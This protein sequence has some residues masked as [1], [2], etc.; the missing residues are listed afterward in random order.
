MRLLDHQREAMARS[1]GRD[2]FAFFME[3]G[4]GKSLTVIEDASRSRLSRVL[5][6]APSGVHGTWSSHHLSHLPV[7]RLVWQNRPALIK[8][9]PEICKTEEFFWLLMSYDSL[10]TDAGERAATKFLKTSE[11]V[12]LILDES[13]RIKSPSAN[14]TRA[15]LRISKLTSWRRVLSGTPI[16][17]KPLDIYSQMLALSPTYWRE[18]FGVPNYH[19]FKHEFAVWKKVELP[20]GARFEKLIGYRHLDRLSAT[21]AKDSFRVLKRDVIKDLPEKTYETVYVPA[22]DEQ[23]RLLAQLRDEL[24]ME[25]SS[26]VE[27][28]APLAIAR[29]TRAQQ[30]LGGTFPGTSER[31]PCPRLE[32]TLELLED[33]SQPTIVWCRFIEDVK[34]IAER[35]DD[36]VILIGEM[37]QKERT[38]A[39]SAFTSENGPRTLITTIGLAAEGYNFQ[40]AT[41]AIYY[42][43]TF[44]LQD[45]LQSEDRCHRIGQKNAVT[46]YDLVCEDVKFDRKLLEVLRAKR[47]AAGEVLRDEL[48]EWFK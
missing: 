4:T 23:L 46:Y 7:Q 26:G 20:S 39:I 2:F 22:S 32:A 29:M 44:R 45:R 11:H 13:Q 31:I 9:L 5:V 16:A 34:A 3:Q 37:S 27:V 24:R 18:R 21:I 40:R 1:E 10:A 41:R 12:G 35:S 43:N 14:R 15:A 47:D 42:G 6:V 48:E 28:T 17:D 36:A 30:V 8:S 25:L 38:A 19:V 33:D